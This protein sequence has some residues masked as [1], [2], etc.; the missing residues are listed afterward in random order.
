MA[1]FVCLT[2][3]RLLNLHWFCQLFIVVV[4]LQGSVWSRL[5]SQVTAIEFLGHI[6]GLGIDM[7]IS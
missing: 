3:Y 2:E 5:G 6:G 1:S 7:E 4:I